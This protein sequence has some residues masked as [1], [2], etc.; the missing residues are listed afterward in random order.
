MNF[1]LSVNKYIHIY[2]AKYKHNTDMTCKIG[3]HKIAKI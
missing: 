3:P 2:S 1:V